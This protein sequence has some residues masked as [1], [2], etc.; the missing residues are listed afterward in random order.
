MLSFLIV[1]W[2]EKTFL[3]ILPFLLKHRNRQPKYWCLNRHKKNGP[4]SLFKMKKEEMNILWFF[5]CPFKMQINC[6]G[7]ENTFLRGKRLMV[8]LLLAPLLLCMQWN[9]FQCVVQ[10]MVSLI[11]PHNII[12]IILNNKTNFVHIPYRC[13]FICF[14]MLLFFNSKLLFF[15]FQYRLYAFI[16]WPQRSPAD[17]V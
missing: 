14:L 12:I 11:L 6:I 8:L 7:K 10:R 3:N 17:L 1:K 4:K 9:S 15:F 16:M 2:T 5:L 13:V